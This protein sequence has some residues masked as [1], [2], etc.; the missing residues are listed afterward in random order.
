M[1]KVKTKDEDQEGKALKD[2]RFEGRQNVECEASNAAGPSSSEGMNTFYGLPQDSK[3]CIIKYL[4]GDS[5][6]KCSQ[7]TQTWQRQIK[8]TTRWK[9]ICRSLNIPKC[10]YFEHLDW[11]PSKQWTDACEEKSHTWRRAFIREKEVEYE[12]LNSHIN[13]KKVMEGRNMNSK[14]YEIVMH[15]E[16]AITNYFIN[17]LHL[18]D[19]NRFACPMRLPRGLKAYVTEMVVMPVPNQPAFLIAGLTNGSIEMWRLDGKHFPH[20]RTLERHTQ[21]VKC[22]AISTSSSKP[23]IPDERC[24]LVSG[25]DDNTVRLWNALTGQCLR[26]YE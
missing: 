23:Q 4:D 21:A 8:D 17:D 16:W 12:W 26:V 18:L 9:A 15:G 3:E 5:L 19:L 6:L 25:S 24:L 14:A 13:I 1:D 2:Q 10:R 11:Y 20:V 7:V 22:L